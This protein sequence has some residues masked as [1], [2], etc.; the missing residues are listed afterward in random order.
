MTWSSATG[1]PAGPG[2]YG[3][4]GRLR[5]PLWL[6]KRRGIRHNVLNAKQRERR[7]DV[8]EAGERGAV[9][10]A[11]N[12]AGRRNGHQARSGDCGLGGLY[13]LGPRD[14]SRAG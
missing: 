11:T 10:I 12:M 5:T 14:T 8:A 3:L 4:C 13:V 7:A 6:L 2:G 9:T 1:R